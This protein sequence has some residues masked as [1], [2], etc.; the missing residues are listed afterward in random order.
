MID[1]KDA[2][3]N[4]VADNL[5][6][7]PFMIELF[8][9]E[10]EYEFDSDI[11]PD[12]DD[13]R[14]PIQ[15]EHI[16]IEIPADSEV[17]KKIDDGYYDDL[18]I[19]IKNFLRQ[20]DL[21]VYFNDVYTSDRDITISIDVPAQE[22]VWNAELHLKT[23]EAK[24]IEEEIKSVYEKKAKLTSDFLEGK[25]DMQ[26]LMYEQDRLDSDIRKIMEEYHPEA[27]N[28]IEVEE[29]GL[30]DEE[31]D[32]YGTTMKGEWDKYNELYRDKIEFSGTQIPESVAV[33]EGKEQ[34]SRKFFKMYGSVDHLQKAFD[35]IKNHKNIARIIIESGDAEKYPEL[36]KER[37]LK[38]IATNKDSYN[39]DYRAYKNGG[40]LLASDGYYLVSLYYKDAP[41]VLI[42]EKIKIGD[43]G[44][45][46]EDI[47]TYLDGE[48]ELKS[49]MDKNNTSDFVITTYQK[50]AAN[51]TYVPFDYDK[52]LDDQ[53]TE[54]G[55]DASKLN[56]DQKRLILQPSEAPENF[57]MDG[58]VTPTQAMKIWKQ[59]LA[60]A[61]LSPADIKKAYNA[62]FAANGYEILLEAVPNEDFGK[63]DYSGTISIP[64][65]KYPA[66]SVQEARDM[67][68]EFI[69]ENDL[70]SGNWSGG[71][72]YQNG[73]PVAFV[74]YNGRVWTG[75]EGNSKYEEYKFEDGG[76]LEFGVHAYQEP[77]KE[78]VD[79]KL[80]VGKRVR[81]VEMQEDPMPIE[82]GDEG[83]ILSVDGLGQIH[84][85]WDSGRSLALIPGVD[86]Y[87]IINAVAVY[88]VDY[89][90]AEGNLIDG[91]QIDENS[92]SV[93]WDL[94]FHFGYEKKPG[95]YV[96]IE[97][98]VEYLDEEAAKGK[99]IKQKTDKL[100]VSFYQWGRFSEEEEIDRVDLP[101]TRLG[102]VA[103]EGFVIRKE[104]EGKSFYA[105]END[106][107]DKDNDQGDGVG[108]K[109]AYAVKG[110]YDT[111]NF[112][113]RK[114]KSIKT[115]MARKKI[116][117][118]LREF[119]AGSLKTSAGQKV[120][121]RDQAIAIA[122]SEAR[123]KDG[124]IL[125][126]KKFID[127]KENLL[128]SLFKKYAVTL[129][130][131]GIDDKFIQEAIKNKK[132]IESIVD[133]VGERYKL[134]PVIPETKVYQAPVKQ[135]KYTC[136][137]TDKNGKVIGKYPVKYTDDAYLKSMFSAIGLKL[138]ASDKYEV[139]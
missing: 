95:M 76:P 79:K 112:T 46:D 36:I 49:L 108:V 101:Q 56:E 123:A 102:S 119:K 19:N 111:D 8:G 13:A 97:P 11:R 73:K 7:Q 9:E 113:A 88:N 26:K 45:D 69:S 121:N 57:S 80:L 84:V 105:S 130:D 137:V 68:I 54:K 83:T 30:T 12:T 48:D 20:Y 110:N 116:A 29:G 71:Q 31:I 74:S 51:G 55:F 86:K 5:F 125:R 2:L 3:E 139:Q 22:D 90:D 67:A 43:P 23:E 92:E 107:E 127:Y 65:K 100:K 99:K 114:G 61:G 78:E 124:N 115:P 28:G 39:A 59:R 32:R 77:K 128:N 50:V 118:V 52:Y 94:F 41:N 47:L 87:E 33:F 138:K 21:D 120:T 93:A 58:E 117:K 25:M 135:K 132:S 72:I 66:K 85:K 133:G 131:A 136:V 42:D 134:T 1:K 64:A 15:K 4:I 103:L 106:I 53:L 122:I 27:A 17:I 18:V 70:G 82:P 38:V 16:L 98:D 75:K 62:N 6:T 96:K 35:Y 109:R 129:V 44:E 104:D 63:D 37:D 91:T 60:S 24:R 81:L 126:D 89:F 14:N 10:P 40:A 34:M